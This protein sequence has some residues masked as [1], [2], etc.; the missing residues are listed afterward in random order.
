MDPL[1]I[2]IIA[3]LSTGFAGL[4]LRYSFRSKC[5]HV[6]CCYGLI[7]IDRDVDV[8]EQCEKLELEHNINTDDITPAST[9]SR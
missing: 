8:E 2:T 9:V 7:S 5:S 1:T 4:I 6:V 3:T